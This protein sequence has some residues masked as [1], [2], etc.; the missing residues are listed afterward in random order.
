LG[1]Y[2]LASERG[3]SLRAAGWNLIG[4]AGGGSWSREGRPR[5]DT[6]PTQTK[7]LFETTFGK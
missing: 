4:E 2:I 1:T 5:V 7:L 3:T 6:A